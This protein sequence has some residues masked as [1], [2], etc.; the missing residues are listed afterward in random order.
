M[1]IEIYSSEAW[2][3]AIGHY[4]QCFHSPAAYDKFFHW[5]STRQGVTYWEGKL[6]SPEWVG[7][8]ITSHTFNLT[9]TLTHS[10]KVYLSLIAFYRKHKITSYEFSS[11]AGKGVSF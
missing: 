5:G 10:D 3:P 4:P 2:G 7:G 6:G 11:H 8:V 1:K 9:D